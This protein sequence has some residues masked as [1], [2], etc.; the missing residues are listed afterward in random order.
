[1]YLKIQNEY[2]QKFTGFTCFFAVFKQTTKRGFPITEQ[3]Q[4]INV[5]DALSLVQGSSSKMLSSWILFIM[6]FQQTY[7]DRE[8]GGG[9][10]MPIF[11]N[12]DIILKF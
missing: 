2:L 3:N 6:M 5:T 8:D 11:I 1:M 12:L 7:P 4:R 9:D 10:N